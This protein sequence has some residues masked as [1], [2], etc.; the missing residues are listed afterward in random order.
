LF[1]LSSTLAYAQTGVLSGSVATSS[2]QPVA[3]ASITLSPSNRGTMTDEHGHYTLSGVPYGEY[4]LA[5]TSLEI[6]PVETRVA[7]NRPHQRQDITANNGGV[8]RL[9][10]ANVSRNS[11]KWEIETQGF[12]VAVVET[13]EASVRNLT[14][15]ELLD[16]TVG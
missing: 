7:I 5:V 3:G 9:G 4:T 12:A 15:N 6:Q 11:E 16:R 8:T 2:G 13:K 1:L 14:T 10:E